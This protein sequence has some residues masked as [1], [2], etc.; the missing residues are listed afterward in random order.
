MRLSR[1]QKIVDYVNE[2]GVV[3]FSDLCKE[4]NSSSATM[5]RDLKELGDQGLIEKVHGGAR[6]VVSN[7]SSE[8]PYVK[9][10]FMNVEEKARIARK[11][12]ESIQDNDIIIL[13]SSTTTTELAKLLQKSSLKIGVITNDAQIASLLTFSQSIDV[14]LI[15]GSV[16]KGF[17][18]A[19]GPYS[20]TMWQQFHASKLFLGVDAI[21]PDLG[22]M[23]YLVDEIKS[24]QI[25]IE[26][27]KTHI[28]LAD[29]TK[30]SV[31]SLIQICP[32]DKIDTIITGTELDE[33]V[34]KQYR[35]YDHLELIQS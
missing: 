23:G 5:R 33:S 16:R 20:E 19:L 29:H 22:I 30:F 2:I 18:S 31:S 25:M 21:D 9:R 7:Q 11:A 14:V 15:G 8:T 6:S 26:Q 4:F 34:K 24:K 35:K 10:M 1:L 12:F 3:S 17:Y 27:S 13:D 28:I 32:I